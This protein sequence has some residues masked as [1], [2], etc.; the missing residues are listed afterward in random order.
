MPLTNKKILVIDDTQ[1]IRVFLGISLQ[2]QGAKFLEA[3]NANDGVKLC[4]QEHPDLVVL[5]LGLPDRDGLDILPEIKPLGDKDGKNPKVIILSVRKEQSVKD[6]AFLL[7]A[8]DY[9]SK[10]FLMEELLEIIEKQL[11]LKLS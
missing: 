1:S 8:D 3:A 5:D 9:L 11:E 4:H 6:K 7:G 2:A 10:P